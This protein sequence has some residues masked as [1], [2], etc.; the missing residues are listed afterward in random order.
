[1][2]DQPKLKKQGIPFFQI[3]ATCWVS[4]VV[5]MEMHWVAVAAK[6]AGIEAVYEML[7]DESSTQIVLA[8][9]PVYMGCISIWLAYLAIALGP[10]GCHV[11]WYGRCQALRSNS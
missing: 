2:R 11:S 8:I 7:T 10:G 4:L 6:Q 3:G 5:I 9:G 1:M